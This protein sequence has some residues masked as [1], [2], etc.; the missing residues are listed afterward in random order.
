MCASGYKNSK[1][2]ITVK[3]MSKMFH[4]DCEEEDCDERVYFLILLNGILCIY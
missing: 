2:I 1:E 4:L 3:I